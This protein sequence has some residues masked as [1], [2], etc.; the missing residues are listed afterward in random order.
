MISFLNNALFSLPWPWPLLV[1]VLFMVLFAIVA[2]C[3][4]SLNLS[5]AIAAFFLGVIVLWCTGFGGFFL[6]LLFFVSCTVIG[7]ISKSIRKN[8]ALRQGFSG[9][10]VGRDEAK[11]PNGLGSSGDLSGKGTHG[12][13]DG[14]AATMRK[15]HMPE[16]EEKKGHRRDFM[17]VLANGLMATIAAL[18]W[19]MTYKKSALIMFGAAVAEA[20]SD[21][22][23]GEIGRLSS[24]NPV[25][26]L[27]LKPVPT[28]LSGGVT[29]LGLFAAFLSSMAIAACWYLW[30]PTT[31]ILEAILVGLLGFAGAVLDS[32]L[33]AGVQAQYYDPLLDQFSE[34]ETRDGR[35]LELSRGIR[36]VDNDMVNL[37]SNTFSAV[38][39]LG[40]SLILA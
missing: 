3:A 29:I 16:V 33:G 10:A 26:I 31:T 8:R 23:S 37:M 36:W 21:T 40:M 15:A 39:A 22:F 14:S 4:K 5:G 34:S 30:L 38:F 13:L 32:V 27:T 17:Q 6:L 11:L 25:S 18:L 19:V 20:T 1:I 9:N 2:Y 24:H 7:K 35:K 28:G 12:G